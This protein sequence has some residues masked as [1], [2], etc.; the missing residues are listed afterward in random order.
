MD[1]GVQ[2]IPQTKIQIN[3]VSARLNGRARA[4]G[5]PRAHALRHGRKKF[6]NAHLKAQIEMDRNNDN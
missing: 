4:A 1:R 6:V 2:T 3:L 5:V